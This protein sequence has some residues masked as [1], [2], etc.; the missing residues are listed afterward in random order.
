MKAIA[1]VP[2]KPNSL[3][4]VELAKPEIAEVAG[5]R[6]ALVR[7]L[8][9]GLCGT[10]RE[11]SAGLYGV[12]PPGFGFLVLGH[13]NF[14]VVEA[15]GPHVTDLTAGD[16]VVAMVR[17]PGH[18]IYDLIG[19]PDLTTDE[20]Y[21]E[22][23]ISLLHGFLAE[24]YV[25]HQDFLIRVPPT[26]RHVGVLLEPMSVVEKGIIHAFD[27]QRRLPIWRPGRAAV[28]GAGP[29]GLL[30]TVA[31][32]LRGLNVV[33]LALSEPPYLN[34]ELVEAVGARYLSTRQV[35]LVEA[36]K[37]FG[38]FDVIFE[39]TGYSPLVFEAM[40]I[41]GKNGVLILSG[42]SGGGREVSVPTDAINLGFVLGNK[43]MVG[44]VNAARQHFEAGVRDL[45]ACETQ[46]PG[47]LSRLLTHRVQGLD[48]YRDVL[49]LFE[50]SERELRPIKAVV[51]VAAGQ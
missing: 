41:L 4:L 12:A 3:G 15:V 24:Y 44:T 47:W 50:A 32:Q 42:I 5:G 51:A 33:T 8:Q 31:L 1:V 6:G 43:A 40:R 13:E 19:M 46:H 26:L 2:G 38:P 17:R 23:G 29:I 48:R 27:L 39:A 9:V 37:Q 28:L 10:D 45:A 35:S 22:R 14:G 20:T 49:E 25:D 30:A 11:I 7:V 34:A 16:H 36:S 21:F 18:S